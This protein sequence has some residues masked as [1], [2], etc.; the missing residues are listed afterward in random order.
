MKGRIQSPD[1]FVV[2]ND[3]GSSRLIKIKLVHIPASKR[4]DEEEAE[5]IPSKRYARNSEVSLL[6][7]PREFPLFL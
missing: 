4:Q 3:E 6:F 5:H 1:P 7:H 2:D